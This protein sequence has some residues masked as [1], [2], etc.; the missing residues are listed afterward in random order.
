MMS[1]DPPQMISL[2]DLHN[3][4]GC[5]RGLHGDGESGLLE[6]TI[7]NGRVGQETPCHNESGN[8]YESRA[9][10]PNVWREECPGK[11][12]TIVRSIYPESSMKVRLGILNTDKL[13]E[14]EIA[15]PKAFKQ[16][17]EK[18]V[19]QGGLGWFIDSRGRSVG[20]P[21]R[22]VA[23]VEIEDSGESKTVGF[24]PAV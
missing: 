24:A 2:F 6:M 7:G 5:V 20:V 21:A 13:I 11:G 18:A 10:C 22:N 3:G 12:I 8:P 4:E 23:F 1:C 17:I 14:L 16:E 19:E 9:H 15:D